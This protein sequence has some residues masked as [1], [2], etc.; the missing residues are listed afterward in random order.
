MLTHITALLTT[1]LELIFPYPASLRELEQITPQQL[2]ARAQ[3]VAE[4]LPHD[5]YSVFRY[6]DPLIRTAVKSLKYQGNRRM[7][8]LFAT[9]LAT[10]IS[11]I[12]LSHPLLVP[13]PISKERYKERGWNQAELIARE[14]AKQ[15]PDVQLE[16]HMLIKIRHTISQTTFK[17]HER[18]H[19]LLGCFAIHQASQA[20]LKDRTIILIDDVITT[21]STILEAKKTLLGAGAQR[22]VAFTV[23]H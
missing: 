16:T 1:I 21:G 12:P 6:K 23:A 4:Q 2:L 19:N 9:I 5:I 18:L 22:V 14:I 11:A 10:R 15:C 7:A 13:I 17:R 3:P 20:I 8:K